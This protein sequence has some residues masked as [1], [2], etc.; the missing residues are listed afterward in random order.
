MKED[1][2]KF[3]GSENKNAWMSQK[4][5]TVMTDN[6]HN[7]IWYPT[8]GKLHYLEMVILT[9]TLEVSLPWDALHSNAIH[10][11]ICFNLFISSFT[12]G[13]FS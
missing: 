6:K 9:G 4:N 8:T 1:D 13:L 3:E 2:G 12:F 5:L 7:H 11:F 10:P